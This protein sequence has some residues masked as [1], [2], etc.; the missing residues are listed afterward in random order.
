MLER[1]VGGEAAV[2]DSLA[3]LQDGR[4]VQARQLKHLYF[5]HVITLTE[6]SNLIHSKQHIHT[7]SAM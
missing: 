5:L 7:Q 2:D 6:G 4:T 1:L 3:L